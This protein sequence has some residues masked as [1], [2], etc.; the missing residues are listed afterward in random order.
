LNE[1]WK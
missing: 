1:S